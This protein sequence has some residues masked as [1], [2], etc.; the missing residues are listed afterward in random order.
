MSKQLVLI[1]LT[2]SKKELSQLREMVKSMV[3]NEVTVTLFLN[4]K[5]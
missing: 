3:E 2:T 4:H 5:V 1:K